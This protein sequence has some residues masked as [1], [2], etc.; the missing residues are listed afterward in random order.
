MT[1]SKNMVK[2]DTSRLKLWETLR[3]LRPLIKGRSGTALK[4]MCEV[5]ITDGN[6]LF[7]IPGGQYNHKCET[8]G[9]AKFTLKFLRLYDI[10]KLHEASKIVIT[11]NQGYVTFGALSVSTNTC[12][13]END[14][15][16]RSIDIPMNYTDVDILKLPS[17]GYTLE[18][19][20]F[21]RITPMYED[22]KNRL[23]EKLVKAMTHLALYE[24]DRE[25]LKNFI[26][27]HIARNGRK[28]A[29]KRMEQIR[30][31]YEN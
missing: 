26:L 6:V 13:F 23:E 15:V 17:I 27:N 2:I 11:V 10:V 28:E 3:Q 4:V 24:L 16:L 30:E 21:N 1:H 31:S 9:S 8:S 14:N 5:T 18:E 22:A 20:D 19:L 29:K 7:K 25:K 12:F